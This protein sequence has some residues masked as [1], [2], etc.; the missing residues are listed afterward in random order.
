MAD[1]QHHI[2][3]TFDQARK[4]GLKRYYT[5]V[6]CPHGHLAER[7]T[8]NRACVVCDNDMSRLY[9]LKT[10]KANPERQKKYRSNVRAKD[11]IRWLLWSAKRSASK[12][13][14]EFSIIHSDLSLPLCCPCCSENFSFDN[15]SSRATRRSPSI[16]RINNDVGYVAGN[17]AIICYQCNSLKN[18][19]TAQD[20]RNIIRYITS[21]QPNVGQWVER[22][23]RNLKL[24]AIS[25]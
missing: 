2:I 12:R 8:T 3:L 7:R 11:P 1:E 19:G 9:W 24:K 4:E 23:D 13:G 21:H 15:L 16:D 22:A 17:V 20:F 18:N 10:L 6:A 25:T 14:L 5:G